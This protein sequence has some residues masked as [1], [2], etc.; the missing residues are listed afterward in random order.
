GTVSGVVFVN[1]Q[2]AD[3]VMRR[4]PERSDES[5]H[6]VPHGFDPADRPADDVRAS[7]DRLTIVYTGR[8]YE[9]IRTPEPLLRALASLSRRRH[10]SRDLHVAFVG[11]PVASHQRLAADLGLDASVEFT[12]RLPFAESAR[13]A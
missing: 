6:V 13:R 2:T 12:G 5:V 9:G 8:F 10:L 7:D 4:Y 3:R 1:Q 11:T